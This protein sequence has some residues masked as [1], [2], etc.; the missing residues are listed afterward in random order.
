MSLDLSMSTPM[1]HSQFPPTALAPVLDVLQAADHVRHESE[2]NSMEETASSPGMV[3]VSA[4]QRRAG[5]GPLPAIRTVHQRRNVA[6]IVQRRR[7][8]VVDVPIRC[9]DCRP[10]TRRHWYRSCCCC[11]YWHGNWCCRCPILSVQ[12]ATHSVSALFPLSH[13]S[14]TRRL[15]I[16]YS[17]VG[18]SVD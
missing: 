1:P 16:A 5:L 7:N 2:D 11:C 14:D 12:R 10:F 6:K 13:C 3:V 4:G 15:L 9:F 18:G 8:L 17:V